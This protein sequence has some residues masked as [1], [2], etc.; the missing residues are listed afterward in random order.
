VLPDCRNCNRNSNSQGN[1]RHIGIEEAR[2]IVGNDDGTGQGVWIGSGCRMLLLQKPKKWRVVRGV[3]QL[4]NG[5]V[6]GR[7]G[8]FSNP[9]PARGAKDMTAKMHV[10]AIN[11]D[12]K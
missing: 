10:S 3:M 2:R 1:H 7:R 6:E 9:I 12:P 4:V 11:H 8:H 5:V